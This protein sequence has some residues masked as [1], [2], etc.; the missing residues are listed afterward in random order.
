M[1]TL[2]FE[3]LSSCDPSYVIEL[4]FQL[5]VLSYSHALVLLV[6]FGLLL[7]PSKAIS[8]IT[9]SHSSICHHSKAYSCL[10]LSVNPLLD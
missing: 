8:K 4:H 3:K 2:L 9:A 1:K 6:Q 10:A 5:H 7:Y